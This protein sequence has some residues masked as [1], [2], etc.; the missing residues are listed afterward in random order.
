MANESAFVFNTKVGNDILT[1]RGDDISSFTQNLIAAADP[2]LP[3]LLIAVQGNAAG[4]LS[5]APAAPNLAQTSASAPVWG[6]THTQDAAPAAPVTG[7]QC[8]HG[9]RVYKTGNSAKGK[10][11]AYFC[12]QRGTDCKPMDNKG[13]YWK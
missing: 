1:V 7:F 11:E 12:P 2:A 8:A 5:H 3:G 9:Q 4:G 10:W 13:N 6:A